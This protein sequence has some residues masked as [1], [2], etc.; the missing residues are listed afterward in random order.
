MSEDAGVLRAVALDDDVEAGVGD[1]ANG[2]VWGV[3]ARDDLRSRPGKKVRK[4][5][6]KNERKK[7]S[8]SVD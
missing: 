7:E 1:G 3:Q 8:R 4:N 5:E 6:R 2:G